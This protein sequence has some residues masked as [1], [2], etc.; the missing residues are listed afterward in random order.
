M[1]YNDTMCKQ[2]NCNFYLRVPISRT[3]LSKKKQLQTDFR[4]FYN[5]YCRAAT[6][7]NKL[8]SISVSFKILNKNMDWTGIGEL[9]R[10][11]QQ[12]THIKF[13]GCDGNV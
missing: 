4:I 11:V 5:F 12:R 10:M 2:S 9:K 1:K 7:H 3:Q 6:F 8:L 13:P